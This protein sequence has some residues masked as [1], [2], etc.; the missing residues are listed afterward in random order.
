MFGSKNPCIDLLKQS[1]MDTDNS[2]WMNTFCRRMKLWTEDEICNW[3]R[4][5]PINHLRQH[6]LDLHLNFVDLIHSN[7]ANKV[8]LIG[9]KDNRLLFTKPWTARPEEV[10]LC[11]KKVR[12]DKRSLTEE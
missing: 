7:L 11:N 3:T 5:S 2:F 8:V 9:G 4:F 12:V 1:G 6:I 10:E